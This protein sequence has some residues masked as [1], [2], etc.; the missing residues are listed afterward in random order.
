MSLQQKKGRKIGGAGGG[1]GFICSTKIMLMAVALLSSALFLLSVSVAMNVTTSPSSQRK[2]QFLDKPR[3]HK[4]RRTQ[5]AQIQ[6]MD[7][8]KGSGGADLPKDAVR[9]AFVSKMK[10]D[11][12]PNPPSNGINEEGGPSNSNQSNYAESKSLQSSD[13]I[14]VNWLKQQRSDVTATSSESTQTTAAQLLSEPVY[15]TP[16][17]LPLSQ[18]STLKQCYTDTTIYKEHLKEKEAR[19]VPY[20][21]K[22]NLA[23]LLLPKSGS[24]TGRFMMKNEFDAI[25]QYI[26]ITPPMN[27]I[28]FVREPLSRFFSQYDEAYVRT[29]PWLK[30]QNPFYMSPPD[31][32]TK[33]QQRPHPFPFLFE[34]MRSYHDYE[35]AFCPIHT[36]KSRKDCI[37]RPTQE[38]GTLASRLERFVQ[39]YDGRTPFDIHLNLQVPLL[40]S[41]TNGLSMHLTEL[42]NTTN[43]EKDWKSIAKRYI[44]E[45]ATFENAKGKHGDKGSGVIEGRAFPRRFNKTLVGKETERRICELALLDYCCLNF[46]LPANCATGGGGN[47]ADGVDL[48]QSK[49]NDGGDGDHNLLCKMDYNMELGRIRIQPGKFPEKGRVR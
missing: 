46:P 22:Y 48:Q 35:D 9:E 30:S 37:Y 44:H 32:N 10:S 12:K 18:L 29:A 16:G 19:R 28:T 40:S 24:S 2:L 15:F 1:G 5:Q 11:D 27:S 36:R 17:S 20:S 39:E 14:L 42:Y 13:E 3:K 31:N 8:A 6:Q 47:N 43:S 38:N 45:E 21:K 4:L 41:S 49:N 23:Y 34:N 33:K 7:I 26:Q 25:E